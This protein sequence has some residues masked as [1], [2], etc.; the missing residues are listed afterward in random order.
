MRLGVNTVM[1]LNEN[2]TFYSVY[3]YSFLCYLG[4]FLCC[5]LLRDNKMCAWES[6]SAAFLGEGAG[7][8]I[9]TV[10]V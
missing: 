9:L 1:Q 5:L 2:D 6:M 3:L 7:Q 10:C 8:K 4:H